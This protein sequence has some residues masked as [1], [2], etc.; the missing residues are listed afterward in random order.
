MS[1]V[2]IWLLVDR[3]PT[4]ATDSPVPGFFAKMNGE[5]G[6]GANISNE[7]L[8]RRGMII[9]YG[10][11]IRPEQDEHSRT[12]TAQTTNTKCIHATIIFLPTGA[13]VYGG[14]SN[15]DIRKVHTCSAGSALLCKLVPG[16]VDRLELVGD[17]EIQ[18]LKTIDM[19]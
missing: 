10:T 11:P 16:H 1:D 12:K 18:V 3:K 13:Q 19:S 17:E 5:F 15:Q 7:P 8:G 6:A 9:P 14:V 4:M 2:S